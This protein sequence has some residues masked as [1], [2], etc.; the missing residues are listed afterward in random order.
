VSASASAIRP[1][2]TLRQKAGWTPDA[3]MKKLI[4]SN[5]MVSGINRRG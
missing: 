3:L 1:T 5:E 4:V 2:T